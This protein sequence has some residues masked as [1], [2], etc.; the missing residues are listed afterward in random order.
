MFS[1]VKLIKESF[2]RIALYRESWLEYERMYRSVHSPDYLSL[3]QKQ[4]RNSLFVPLT[5]S[6]INI[7]NSTFCNAFFSS[8]NP[9]EILGVGDGDEE[10]CTELKIL[11]SHYF[12]KS[13][14]F[15]P[16]S[17][18]FLNAC[19]YGFGAVHLSWECGIPKTICLPVDSLA[20]DYEAD[21]FEDNRYIAYQ[22]TQTIEDI[23]A[24]FKSGFYKSTAELNFLTDDLKPYT[25]KKVYEIYEKNE[26]GYLVTSFIDDKEVRQVQ[27]KSCPIKHGIL[28]YELRSIDEEARKSQIACVGDSL[29]RVIKALND[30][31]NIKRNQ[32]MDLIERYL[33]PE[34]YIPAS[35]GVNVEDAQKS[36]GIKRCENSTGI[37]HSPVGAGAFEFTNDVSMLLKD[38]EDVS[39]INGVMRGLT[40]ASDR[41]SATAIQTVSANSTTRLE[42]MIKLINETLFEDWAKDF[43]RL[44]YLNVSDEDA[45]QILE[46]PKPLIGK[47]G[48]RKKLD[49]DIE[50][51]FGETINKDKKIADLVSILQMVGNNPNANVN[52][53]MEKIIKLTLG[54]NVDAK[55]ILSPQEQVNTL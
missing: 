18:A 3:T 42:N 22:F 7:A 17:R 40:N 41:R 36:G 44:V 2:S 15:T 11:T 4:E 6:T 9:I 21:S 24:R 35:C 23:K 34:V 30:E 20:Y 8:N 37:M 43:V 38:I 13:R 19:I 29:V 25:R 28:L 12:K 5:F 53:L 46:K 54:D 52:A 27:F 39:A 49:F 32:R 33:N 26:K 55:K 47:Q 50:V 51:N 10:L 31:L 1:R 14:P 48:L 16:L 45:R